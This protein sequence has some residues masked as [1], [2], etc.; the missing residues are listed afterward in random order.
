MY[1]KEFIY[2][3]RLRIKILIIKR[4]F[5]KIKNQIKNVHENNFFFNSNIQVI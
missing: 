1:K 5:K 3:I 2:L 4:L